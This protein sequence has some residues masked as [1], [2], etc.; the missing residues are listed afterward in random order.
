MAATEPSPPN[1]L[2]LPTIQ[3]TKFKDWVVVVTGAAAG[4]GRETAH[5]FAA[6]GA[7]LI[8][9]DINESGLK[10]TQSLIQASGGKADTRKCDVSDEPDV[11]AAIAWT[12]S[13]YAR[14][15]VLANLAGIYGFQP[16]TEYS[17]ELYH[18]HISVNVNGSFFLTRAVLPHMQKAGFGRIIHTSST[19]YADP[20][21]GLSA[22][23]M[24][25][26]AV[27]GL[28]RSAA[29]EAGPGVTVNAVMPGLIDTEEMRSKDGYEGIREKILEN[30][31]VKRDGKPIDVA[32]TIAFLASP[33][34][35]FMTGQVVNCS[36]GETFSF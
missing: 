9:L 34:A 15:D 28:V 14:I 27:V 2:H 24:S 36:G 1:D 19:T 11:N 6:Q 30:R 18:R 25:K 35:G 13:T 16:L 10:E 32:R 5:H 12:I 21:P 33:E 17:S 22:Y 8:L 26:A 7:Q 4:I 31:A 20:K 3:P 29:V 23:V